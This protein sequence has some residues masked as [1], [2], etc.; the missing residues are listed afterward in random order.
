MSAINGALG[1]QDGIEQNSPTIVTRAPIAR[2]LCHCLACGIDTRRYSRNMEPQTT[3]NSPKHSIHLHAMPSSASSL[4]GEDT[5]DLLHAQ[6]YVPVARIM[7]RKVFE[8]NRSQMMSHE[9]SQ[10]WKAV[11]L[12]VCERRVAGVGKDRG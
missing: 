1:M 6:G 8:R 12:G 2:I 5:I 9:C 7:H 4:L 10:K 11:V 3:Q